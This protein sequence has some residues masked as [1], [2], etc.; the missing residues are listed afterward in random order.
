MD[1]FGC[2]AEQVELVCS[3]CYVCAA[4]QTDCCV[5]KLFP[6]IMDGVGKSF[7]NFQVEI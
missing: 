4:T 3:L 7:V 5:M 1:L 6:D 2:F